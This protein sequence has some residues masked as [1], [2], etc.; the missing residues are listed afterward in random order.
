MKKADWQRRSALFDEAVD[1]PV[2]ARAA[3]LAALEKSEPGH[4][5]ALKKMLAQIGH[6]QTDSQRDASPSLIGVGTREFEATLDA[7][8]GTDLQLQ[9]G[10]EVGAWRIEC[11]SRRGATAILKGAQRSSFCA[12]GWAKRKWWNAFCA[13]AVC[14]HA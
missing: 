11:G 9:A 13:S 12:P 10:D 3:W 5:A 7:A 6:D 1:L 14:W 2:D 8:T 4:I